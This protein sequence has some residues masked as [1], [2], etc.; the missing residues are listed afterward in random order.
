MQT[1]FCSSLCSP[2]KCVSHILV[3]SFL[4]ALVIPYFKPGL[5]CVIWIFCTLPNQFSNSFKYVASQFPQMASIFCLHI[6]FLFWKILLI[7]C[8]SSSADSSSGFSFSSEE[9]QSISGDVLIVSFIV[10]SY[11]GTMSVGNTFPWWNR[12]E[13][14]GSQM[15]CSA[16]YQQWPF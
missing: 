13:L 9:K 5:I 2:R 15:F 8:V 7:C 4:K 6:I 10:P 3:I 1:Q 16:V 12:Q 14:C 11:G